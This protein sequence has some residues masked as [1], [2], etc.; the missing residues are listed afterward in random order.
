LPDDP[1]VKERQAKE[2]L[3]R[4]NIEPLELDP[5]A[6]LGLVNGDNFSTAA[7]ILLFKDVSELM[8]LNLL[9]AALMV[10]VLRGT[11]RSFHPLLA[12]VKVIL[13]IFMTGV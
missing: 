5:K 7:A 2:T 6:G 13:C 3:E 11:S 8:L 10:Q 4:H 9:I 12:F 1:T